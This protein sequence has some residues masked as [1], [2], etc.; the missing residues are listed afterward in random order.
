MPSGIA[1]AERPSASREI[2]PASATA[3][4]QRWLERLTLCVVALLIVFL[5]CHEMADSDLWW[6]LRTGQLIVARGTVPRTDW[7]T[8]SSPN[9]PWINLNWLWELLATGIWQIA[10]VP[11][12]I[13][14]TSCLGVATFFVLLVDRGRVSASWAALLALPPVLLFAIRFPVRPESI[15]FFFLSVTLLICRRARQQPGLL[16]LLPAI[17]VLWVNCHGS[18]ILEIVVIGCFAIES[19]AMALWNRGKGEPRVPSWR[20]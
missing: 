18:F 7:F 6:H 5:G 19:V 14:A 12:L 17:Q 10:G 1:R 8:Y 3:D 16:W 11:G 9:A 4:A 13:I 15:A 20:A 2:S